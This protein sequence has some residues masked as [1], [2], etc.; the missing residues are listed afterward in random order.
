MSEAEDQKLRILVVDDEAAVCD[1]IRRLLAYDGHTVQAC[2]SSTRALAAF[3]TGKFDLV[4]MDYS[5]PEMK[6]DQLALAISRREPSLPI[7]MVSGNAPPL[8]SVPGVAFI[9]NK[10]VMLDDLRRAIARVQAVRFSNAP[11]GSGDLAA[12]P[13][14]P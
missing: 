3:D 8:G 13:L 11:R 6:G 2:T 1:C 10:P 12:I 7:V 14:A 5:M 4:F 9:L